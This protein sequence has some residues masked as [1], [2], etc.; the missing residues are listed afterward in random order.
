M[1]TKAELKKSVL[2][3]I[4]LTFFPACYASPLEGTT[5]ESAAR[6]YDLDPALLFSVALTESK[7]YLDK[8]SV[9]PW[10]WAFNSPEGSFYA[11]S[12]EAAVEY[13]DGLLSRY[14]PRQIDV[15]I[16]QINLGW[17]GYRVSD[18]FDLL[19]PDINIGVGAAVLREALDS[20]DDRLLGVGRYHH[21]ANEKKSRAYGTRVL[22]RY[23]RIRDYFNSQGRKART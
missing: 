18:Y 12:Y 11:P 23:L 6:H 16:M 22:N 20:C 5:W 4:G 7:K 2:I 9:S 8:R 15:G 21:W 3:W 10:P 17:Q 19:D 1:N 13:L 14:E